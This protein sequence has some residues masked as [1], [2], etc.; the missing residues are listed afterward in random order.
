MHNVNRYANNFTKT[1]FKELHVA[2]Y[3]S[4]PDFQKYYTEPYSPCGSVIR[5]RATQL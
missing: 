3:I 2:G 1:V 5:H 4:P